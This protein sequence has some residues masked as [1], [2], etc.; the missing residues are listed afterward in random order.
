[1]RAR[2]AEL[3]RQATTEEEKLRAIIAFVARDIQYQ[4]TPFR[5]SAYVPTPGKQVLRER[6]GD[7]KD[8]AALLTA[9]LASVGLRAQMVLLS[10]RSL[11]TT[12]YLPSPRFT[13]AVAR[14]ETSSGPLWVDAT[15]DEEDTDDLVTTP[16][17]PAERNEASDS[18]EVTL[19]EDNTLAGS[20]TFAATGNWSW[21][22][23]SAL[24]RIPETKREEAL[25]GVAARLLENA[26]CES[27]SVE[28][29]TNLDR[30]LR[31]RLTYESEQYGSTAGSFLMVR[32]P[33]GG[34]GTNSL[35]K[36]LDQPARTQDLETGIS[37]GRALSTVRL[38]LPPGYVP[39]DLPPQVSGESS[40]G[41]YRITY[42]M[43]G[44]L[45][46]ARREVTILPLRV[47]AAETPKF[48]EFL[49]EIN[50]ESR[51]QIVFRKP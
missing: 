31:L 37:R 50:R 9:L 35:E 20:F 3:T 29:L 19:R 15:A 43:E 33:W 22:L 38:A 21:V 2:A 28:H 10:G 27:G 49:R 46:L 39:Q 41:S 48:A 18:H 6:Y 26:R 5:L 23:R 1:V 36:R 34:W 47:P 13:H 51:R 32:L 40:W 16:A 30:P 42:E 7:C 11:G 8:K 4:S 44:S 24:L 14:V 17:L 45:L 25:R 12:P